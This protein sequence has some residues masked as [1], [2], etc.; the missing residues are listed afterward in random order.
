VSRAIRGEGLE[1]WLWRGRQVAVPEDF[2]LIAQHADVQAAGLQG[3]PAGKG[4]RIGVESPYGLLLFREGLLPQGSRP[5]G[6]AAEETS[7][8]IIGVQLTP[9]VG[10]HLRALHRH[11]P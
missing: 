10:C 7:I 5:P 9:G 8:I 2:S 4:G 3:D 11:Q 6:S 1:A